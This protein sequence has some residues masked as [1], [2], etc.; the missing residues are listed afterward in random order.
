LRA[1]GLGGADLSGAYLDGADLIGADLSGANL[2]VANLSRADLSWANLSGANL[3]GANLSRANL[4]RANLS[5]ADLRESNLFCAKNVDELVKVRLLI[6][7]Q[8]DIIGWK[9]CREG[10]IVKLQIP[11]SAKRSNATGR[12]CRASSAKVVEIYGGGVGASLYDPT[13]TYRVGETVTCDQWGEDRF[14]ECGGGIHFYLTRE[15]AEDHG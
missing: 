13:F 1:A 7:P 8:G 3:I 12:K 15:E 6:V 5:W 11:A 9:K 14:V 10:K 4:S 2:S